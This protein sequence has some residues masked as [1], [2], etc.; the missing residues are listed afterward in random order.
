MIWL[1][2]RKPLLALA[3]LFG[4]GTAALACSCVVPDPP[5]RAG[6]MAREILQR[7]VAI[8]EADVLTSY[9]S[10]LQMGER[11]RVRRLLWGRAPATLTL[12]RGG[13]PS[14][15]ACGI[16]FQ[17][18]ERRVIILFRAD[19]QMG[20]GALGPH[21]LC[22]DYLTRREYLPVLLRE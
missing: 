6:P 16:A 3:L 5:E 13:Y 12:A 15:A 17:A 10:R 4:G 21:N 20:A 14:S 11:I 8:V 1:S 9:D 19:R 7:A 22:T 2:L 18:G